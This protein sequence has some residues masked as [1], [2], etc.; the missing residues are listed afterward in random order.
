M[1]YGK[2]EPDV[3][4]I[5]RFE[6]EQDI[7][8]VPQFCAKYDH[9][10]DILNYR[11]ILARNIIPQDNVLWEQVLSILPDV[12]FTAPHRIEYAARYSRLKKETVMSWLQK[13]N[14][15]LKKRPPSNYFTPAE[16]RTLMLNA[17]RHRVCLDITSHKDAVAQAENNMPIFKSFVKDEIDFRRSLVYVMCRTVIDERPLDLQR[18]N[19]ATGL[20]SLTRALLSLKCLADIYR[21]RISWLHLPNVEPRFI[22]THVTVSLDPDSLVA[23]KWSTYVKHYSSQLRTLEYELLRDACVRLRDVDW[24]TKSFRPN[25]RTTKAHQIRLDRLLS[26]DCLLSLAS[27]GLQMRIIFIPKHYGKFNSIGLAGT[28]LL[29]HGDFR[30]LYCVIEPTGT[31][32][33]ITT[34]VHPNAIDIVVER[35]TISMRADRYVPGSGWHFE[36]WIQDASAPASSDLWLYRETPQHTTPVGGVSNTMTPLLGIMWAHRGGPL[37]RRRL[38]SVMGLKQRTV[39]NHLK[40][41]RENKM[42][43]VLYHPRIDYVG[44]PVSIVVAGNT[45]TR[46][47]LREFSKW[48]ISVMPFVDLFINRTETALFAELWVPEYRG[49]LTA[50]VIIKTAKEMDLDLI[51]NIVKQVKTCRLTV[52]RRLFDNFTHT[53]RDPWTTQYPIHF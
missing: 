33:D 16:L 7:P 50:Q 5:R 37:S 46:D 28:S 2:T 20:D 23:S 26:E 8:Q 9:L 39:D 49:G 29:S 14:V 30:R 34:A 52:F 4:D 35:E 43:S 51:V 15:D 45:Y 40:R 41:L 36:P 47:A 42:A 22:T 48:I 12:L 1:L 31:S 19:A 44:L 3:L 10:D 24:Y 27:L 53:W 17:I 38:I 11:E 13:I 32:I 6:Q 21:Q 18:I 25:K